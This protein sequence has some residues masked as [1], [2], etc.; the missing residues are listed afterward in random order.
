MTLCDWSRDGRYMIFHRGVVGGVG[1]SGTNLWILPLFGD[2]KPYV[3]PTGLGDQD[4][5]QFSPDGRWIAYASDETGRRE[6]YVAPFPATGAKWQISTNGAEVPRW[7]ADGKELFFE[8]D[9]VDGISA[10]EVN[11][12][13]PSFDAG[14]GRLLFHKNLSLGFQGMVYA[15]SKD[16]QRFVAISTGEQASSPL[17]VVENWTESLKK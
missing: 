10:A 1:R 12:S 14:E 17:F 16:G 2:H 7:R 9:G 4:Q 6:V 15:P 8:Q 11:G 13:G 3:Y 5:A